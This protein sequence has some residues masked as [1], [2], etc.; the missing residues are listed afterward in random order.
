MLGELA[1]SIA[2]EV[3]QP[4]S[5]ITLN[6][7]ASL[8]WL[9]MEPPK[10]A[11][12]RQALSNVLQ[13]AKRA[14]DIIARIRAMLKKVTPE[15]AL[16]DANEVVGQVL[17]LVA[18]ELTKAGVT[19]KTELAPG[20]TYV[21]GDRVQLQQVLLNLV[22]NAIEAMS[23]TNAPRELL[24]KTVNI[25]DRVVVQVE[26]SGPGLDAAQAKHVFEPFYTTK[27]KGLG[28]GLSISRSIIE[29]HGG[30]LSA[31]PRPA[32]GTIFEFSLP[33]AN[34]LEEKVAS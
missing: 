18:S 1:A 21:R 16:V 11:E 17:S 8:Q 29:S 22:V 23:G 19:V 33:A 34:V 30:H 28:M 6:A 5:A 15:R 4:L 20:T 2:H 9:S 10:L 12:A 27:S 32:P 26:D 14:S 7:S 25:G 31:R 13:E 24:I 3:N